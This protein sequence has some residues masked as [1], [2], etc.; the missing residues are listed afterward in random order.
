MREYIKAHEV[1]WKNAKHRAQ[2]S[3]TLTTY[4]APIFGKLPAAAI[5][6]ALVL[7]ALEAIW[8]SKPETASRLR[9]RIES[10][11]DWARVHGYRIG[12]NPA[13][14]KGHLDHILPPRAKVQRVKHHAALPYQEVATFLG[15]LRKREGIAPRAL[16]FVILTTARTGDIIGNHRDEKPPMKWSHVDFAARVWTVPSTKTETEHR[17]P[18]PGSAV[19]LL[20]EMKAVA[21]AGDVVF[22]LEANKPLSNMGMA[23][24]IRRINAHRKTQRL[25]G[26]VDSKQGNRTITVHGFRSTFRDWAAERTNYPRE[27]AEMALAHAIPNAVEAAYRR[28]DLFDKRR[29]LMDAWADYCATVNIGKVVSIRA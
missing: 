8:H 4:A 1:G 25:P 21:I 26:F 18:L 6:T 7:R 29:R 27:V 5:D 20:M 11:L 10:V 12:E 19:R 16:E 23:S 28:G 24:V 3:S 22:G 9:G 17:V 14:W 2:W 15:E 13:R